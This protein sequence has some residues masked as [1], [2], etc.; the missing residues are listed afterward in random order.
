MEGIA[1]QFGSYLLVAFVIEA[2]IEFLVANYLGKYAKYAAAGLGVVLAIGFGLDIF[3]EF[4]NLQ[5][6][7]PYLGSILTGAVLGRGSNFVNDFF[8]LIRSKST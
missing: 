5:S 3:N 8:D 2:L 4:L 1:G 7:I 6:T